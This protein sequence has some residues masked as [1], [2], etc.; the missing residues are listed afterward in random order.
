VRIKDFFRKFNGIKISVRGDDIRAMGLKP[1]PDF[2][3]ILKK[4]LYEKINGKLKTRKDELAYA[5]NLVKRVC[6]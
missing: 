3:I 5:G 4:V 1:C 2:K 6:G